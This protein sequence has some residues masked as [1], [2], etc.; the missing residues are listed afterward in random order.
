MVL[1][2]A[3]CVLLLLKGISSL[4]SHLPKMV[5]VKL[6]NDAQRFANALIVDH[7]C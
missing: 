4:T 5:T 6:P 7:K 1:T 2:V 3:I